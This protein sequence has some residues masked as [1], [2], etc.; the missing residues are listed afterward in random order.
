MCLVQMTSEE[1]QQGCVDGPCNSLHVPRIV[2]CS[3]DSLVGRSRIPIVA[4]DTFEKIENEGKVEIKVCNRDSYLLGNQAMRKRANSR[5][6]HYN[7]PK[8]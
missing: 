7:N 4:S 8:R 6:E 5:K 3:F 1:S 2:T